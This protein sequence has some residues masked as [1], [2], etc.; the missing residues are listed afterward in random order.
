MVCP[1]CASRVRRC[2][3]DSSLQFQLSPIVTLAAL[4]LARQSIAQ[5]PPPVTYDTVLKSPINPNIT[6]SYK[7]PAPGTCTTV[8]ENQTQYTGYINLP[9]STLEPYQQD[10]PIN[11][12]FWFFESRVDPA[13]A[14]LTIWLNGGPGSSSMFGL[15]VENGP[16]E[17]V[18]LS[19]GS[20][21]TQSNPWGWDRSSNILYIDQPTQVGFSYDVLKNQTAS[22]P[23]GTFSD[24][25]PLPSGFPSWSLLNGTFAT[26]LGNSTQN[27]SMI[28]ASASWH[29]LQ[30]FLSA[31]PQYNP[32]TRPNS[33]TT[34][35]TGINLFTE[36]YGGQ[37]GPAFAD[38]FEQQNAKR[39]SGNFATNTTLEIKLKSLGIVNGLVDL[40]LQAPSLP[41]FAYNNT[42]GVQLIDQT[43]EL[44]ALSALND[45]ESGCKAQIAACQASAEKNDPTA[46]GDVL[47]TNNLCEKALN[48]CLDPQG[49]VFSDRSPYDVRFT[50]PFSFSDAY[51]E[52]LNNPD[53]QRSIGAKV[54]FTQGSDVV[55]TQFGLTGDEARGTA[56]H[57]I[58]SLLSLGV[59]VALIYG[60]ADMICNWYGGER[61][62]LELARLTPS[63]ATPFPAA[64]YADIV[65]NSSYVGGV[66]RQYGNLSFSRIYDAGHMVPAYQPETAFTVFT[67]IIQ[68]NDIGM[69][70]DEDLSKFSTIGPSV[71]AHKNNVPEKQDQLCWIRD[72]NATCSADDIQAIWAGQGVVEHGM[73]YADESEYSPTSS[74]VEAGKPGTLPTTQATPTG[75]ST[76]TALTG[77]YT[78]SSTPKPPSSGASSL[79]SQFR[80]QGRRAPFIADENDSDDDADEQPNIFKKAFIIAT[81]V[82]GSLLLL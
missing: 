10:Y 38:Y 14:P 67:R 49:Y 9:P 13:T 73:W 12:F 48:T 55:Q 23:N 50:T 51:I 60:D 46:E 40:S 65:V 18:Q 11:T 20:Y 41:M 62:S 30:G 31:F 7:K 16:C 64:G 25:R 8:F 36:S 56:T 4:G 69:G 52:Y 61:V 82:L 21:G 3:A 43:T 33:T 54:N 76:S 63:Y 19:D 29:F 37:Y 15:F 34:E 81:A 44:N 24:P 5:F 35:P 28:A 66:V 26:R 74:S 2:L 68:G 79:R 59:H 72:V 57:S 22:L 75:T 42:Y 39:L 71:S 80:L 6:I 70:R 45:P 17:V 1:N 58:A 53:V 27:T 78:A 32:G 47:S 77:V